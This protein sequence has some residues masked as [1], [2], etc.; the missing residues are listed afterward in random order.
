MRYFRKLLWSRWLLICLLFVRST[1]CV[2]LC[3]HH[4]WG[5]GGWDEGTFWWQNI[6]AAVQWRLQIINTLH[7]GFCT[8]CAR[9]TSLRFGFKDLIFFFSPFLQSCTLWRE[10]KVTR[11]P[12]WQNL[13]SKLLFNV[14]QAPVS[15]LQQCCFLEENILIH[16]SFCFWQYSIIV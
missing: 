13:Y 3:R 1:K 9:P 6:C 11:L 5:G 2:R 10:K 12:V 4:L 16:P 8:C 15:E 14:L 7:K